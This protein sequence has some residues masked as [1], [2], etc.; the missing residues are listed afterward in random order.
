MRLRTFIHALLLAIIG[1][2]FIDSAHSSDTQVPNLYTYANDAQNGRHPFIEAIEKAQKSLKIATYRLDDKII[3][4]SILGAKKKGIDVQVILETETYSHEKSASSNESSLEALKNANIKIFNHPKWVKQ[5]HHKIIIIDEKEV[6][7]TTGN[8][9][10]ESFDGDKTYTGTR[11]FTI[12]ITDPAMISEINRVFDNDTQEKKSQPSNINL[13][14]GPDKQRKNLLKL[15]HQAK[16]SIS[17][18][19]QDIQDK[20]ICNA[21][22]EKTKKDKVQV[23]IVMTPFPFSKT[24]DNNFKNQMKLKK[25]GAQVRFLENGVYVHAKVMIIDGGT[26]T[27]RAYLGSCNFYPS[28]IDDNRELGVILTGSK[29]IQKLES[30]FEEDFKDAVPNHPLEKTSQNK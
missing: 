19:Q 25:A 26:K 30:I 5:T 13:L 17:I 9:D 3:L 21:L 27:Q 20:D 6:L 11:D 1:T 23:K 22:I 7:L 16:K 12:L 10:H 18:Y 28:S 15:I 4:D 29:N 2:L 8:L 14:W 24:K